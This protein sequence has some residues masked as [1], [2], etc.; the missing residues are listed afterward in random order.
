MHRRGIAWLLLSCGA[1]ALNVPLPAARPARSLDIALPRLSDGAR[2]HLGDALAATSGKTMLC[3]GTHAADFNAIEYLQKLRFYGP[4]L[5]AAGV[6]RLCCVVN[7]E[8]AQCET[9]V[10]LLDVPSDVEVFS[11]PTGEAGRMFGVSR[12]FRPDDDSL[13]PFVKLF[14]VGI[15]P[16]RCCSLPRRASR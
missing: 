4:R 15:G 11:D 16:G 1:S 5:R 8:A 7:G 9:L 6:D 13:S 3:F 10:D 12:G 14:V 2:V